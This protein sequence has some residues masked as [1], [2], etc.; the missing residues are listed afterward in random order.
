MYIAKTLYHIYIYILLYTLFVHI[1]I[2]IYIY[3]AKAGGSSHKSLIQG[4][5]GH[6]RAKWK[7]MCS[8]ALPNRK[9]LTVH[10]YIYIY[11]YVYIHIH[12]HIYI[13]LYITLITMSCIQMCLHHMETVC[14][15]IYI[16]LCV[17]RTYCAWKKPCT[18]RQL[19][20]ATKHGK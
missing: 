2:Y 4:Y 19:L 6:P 5:G 16:H 3:I 13:Y 10:I 8:T 20:V 17:Y 14:I 15:Y 11:M 7:E 9:L 12:I 18:S 1:Y